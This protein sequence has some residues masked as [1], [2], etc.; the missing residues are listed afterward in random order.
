MKKALSAGGLAILLTM[1]GCADSDKRMSQYQAYTAAVN[2]QNDLQ[3]E[4]KPIVDMSFVDSGGKPMK[5]TV[6]LPVQL[7]RV[8]Q[9]KDDEW[10]RFWTGMAPAMLGTA[11]NLA[12]TYINSYY[13]AKNDKYMW[14]AIGES[15]GGGMRIDSGGGDI[16]L[17]GAGNNVKMDGKT[18]GSM[19]FNGMNFNGAEGESSVSF[20]NQTTAPAVAEEELLPEEELPEGEAPEGEAPG[21]FVPTEPPDFPD[22]PVEIPGPP[23][24]D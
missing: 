18:G 7:Q 8:E 16:K 1:T 14:G 11:G 6:N 13:N 12:Q 15:I 22:T 24:A 21:G 3:R 20:G 9:I 23:S 19:S 5:L 2:A 10:I 17:S 4:A